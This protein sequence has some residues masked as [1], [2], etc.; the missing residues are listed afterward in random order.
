MAKDTADKKTR[1]LLQTPN[2]RRQ[3]EFKAKMRADGKIQKTEW[4]DAESFEKGFEDGKKAW[5]NGESLADY[6]HEVIIEQYH[7]VLGYVMGFEK[8]CRKPKD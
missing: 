1:D 5:E 4:V 3:A 2:A 6:V 8:G 7:D